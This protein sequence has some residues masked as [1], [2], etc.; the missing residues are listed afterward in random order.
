MPI[1]ILIV[2][3]D[4][5]LNQAVATFLKRLDFSVSMAYSAEEAIQKLAKQTPDIVLTDIAMEGMSGLELTRHITS[6]HKGI[7][8][9]VMTGL[10]QSYSYENAIESGATDFIFKPFGFKEL[11]LRIKRVINE[12]TLKRENA[13]MMKHL[14]ELAI[15][16]YLT[17]LYNSRHFH[18][19]LTGEMER[20]T[21][22]AHPL[23]LL[24]MDIDKFKN[25]NDSWGH[26]EGDRVLAVLGKVIRACLR[27]MDTGYRYGGEEFTVILPETPLSKACVVGERIRS[28]LEA[29][30]FVP[31][32]GDAVTIT[33]S[34]GVT[35]FSEQDTLESFV[36]RADKAMFQSKKAGRNRLTS[37][38]APP[39]A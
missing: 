20:H 1:S 10:G 35:Q 8:V 4:V 11:K 3:D 36:R 25:Y 30:P 33:I 32:K 24:L 12:I 7:A 13:K 18:R 22:Y 39:P 9:M 31:G 26:L 29:Q 2:D 37:L 17:G 21:R 14:E 16:D 38:P 34:I 6:R 28:A 27:S 19:Q 5:S 23:S 15:T